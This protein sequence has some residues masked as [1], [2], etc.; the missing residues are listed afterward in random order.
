MLRKVKLYT[1]TLMQRSQRN[2]WEHLEGRL[3][4]QS[5]SW[6]CCTPGGPPR[7]P[8]AL[9]PLLSSQ[10]HAVLPKKF[11]KCTECSF[12][13]SHANRNTFCPRVL[14]STHSNMRQIKVSLD[15]EKLL[16]WFFGLGFVSNLGHLD[17]FYVFWWVNI[18]LEALTSLHVWNHDFFTSVWGQER[19]K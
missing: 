14:V 17:P 13:R 10:V 16:W 6:S 5:L 18:P 11:Y 9:L 2:P 15:K 19:P 4:N 1:E 7:P 12:P 8:P 3:R